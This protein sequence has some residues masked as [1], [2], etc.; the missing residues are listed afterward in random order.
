MQNNQLQDDAQDKFYFKAFNFAVLKNPAWKL[1]RDDVHYLKPWLKSESSTFLKAVIF[2]IV[3]TL[4]AISIPKTMGWLIDHTLIKHDQSFTLVLAV[5]I[6]MMGLKIFCDVCYKWLIV[7]AGQRITEKV[8]NEMYQALHQKTS[9]FFDINS[10]GRIISRVVSDVNNLAT[11]FSTNIFSV[12]ADLFVILG[13][14]L[15]MFLISPPAAFLTGFI[16]FILIV[17]MLN[18]TIAM[19]EWSK[20]S[21]HQVSRSNALASDTMNNLAILH[22]QNISSFW[23]SRAQKL[24][25]V[26]EKHTF[27]GILIWGTF[28]SSHV[29]LMGIALSSIISLVFYQYHLKAISL[30]SIV[31]M[32]SY[33]L[34]CFNP[35]LDI[36]EKLNT[37]LQAL[38]SVS[39][40][41]E[42]LPHRVS[43]ITQN[44]FESSKMAGDIE[45]ENLRFSYHDKPVLRNLSFKIPA[46]QMTA[47]VGRT[48]AGKSSLVQVL[49]GHYQNYEGSIKWGSQ[50]LKC[51]SLE[52]RTKHIGQ[53]NQDL[54]FF[55]ES[56]RENLRLFRTD[57]TD[58]EILYILDA[59][60]LKEKVLTL[61]QG[62]ETRYE[63]LAFPF[64][65]GERQLLIIARLLIKN[66]S[67]L[68]LDEA[69]A[70][71]D[72][73][74]EK[75]LLR[76][77]EKLLSERTVLMVAH[78]LQ[79]LNL[80]SQVIVLEQGQ[81]KKIFQKQ[82]GTPVQLE[83]LI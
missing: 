60:S 15:M 3:A 9:S 14:F 73:V 62:L 78:R 67:L 56:L 51:L 5:L 69:T 23:W 34:M 76:G 43:P 13:S 28:S 16:L 45:I 59:L 12:I 44:P 57:I 70:H 1:I 33:T 38:G 52:E 18:V 74:A 83:D 25:S 42:I 10:S 82:P 47:L 63:P 65:Q 79:A 36:S 49:M 4:G 50:D 27:K 11:F 72:Q 64:S 26:Y 20:I 48:G 2:F 75:N 71:L 40:M 41:K 77:L 22:T 6:T 81:V 68:I 53:V 54:F 35:F 32:I 30:G 37:L 29:F 66:P 17:Y 21:R 7:S 46:N 55:T 24:Q 39:R 61:P 80:A 8:R 31:A 19:M 58:Q